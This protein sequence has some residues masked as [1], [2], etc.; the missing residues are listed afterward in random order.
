MA[1]SLARTVERFA[2]RPVMLAALA[3]VA[4][5]VA[6]LA[7]RR[8]RLSGETLLDERGWY[9]PGSAAALFEALDRLDAGARVVYA[10]TALTV[11]MIFPVCYGL[12]FAALLFRLFRGSPPLY[13]LPL[14]LALSDVLENVVVAALALGYDGTPSRLAWLAAGFTLV[15][16]V[17]IV[18]T[19]VALCAGGAI[20]LWTRLHPSR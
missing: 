18:A 11:D 15:K 1:F 3:G 5:C 19:L 4:L 17:L 14:A 6:G 12:L 7:W 2:T 8:A 20:R 9:T 16:T 13:L 10:A